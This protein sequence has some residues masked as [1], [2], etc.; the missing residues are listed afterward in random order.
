MAINNYTSTQREAFPPDQAGRR[1]AAEVSNI[2]PLRRESVGPAVL[3]ERA[4]APQTGD[5]PA[6]KRKALARSM[7]WVICALASSHANDQAG[8]INEA[9]LILTDYRIDPRLILPTDVEPGQ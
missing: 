8:A 3:A 4:S 1:S 6:E 5:I 7:Q 9:R 2:Y